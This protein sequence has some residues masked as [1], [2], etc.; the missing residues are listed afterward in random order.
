MRIYKQACLLDNPYSKHGNDSLHQTFW[1]SNMRI[2]FFNLYIKAQVYQQGDHKTSNNRT[3]IYYPTHRENS[4]N[5]NVKLSTFVIWAISMDA[6]FHF[7][8]FTCERLLK[9]PICIEKWSNLNKKI[10]KLPKD[11]KII[12][13]KW[14]RTFVRPTY[15]STGKRRTL[16]YFSSL[17]NNMIKLLNN[18]WD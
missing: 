7:G 15:I 11:K 9:K 6:S 17:Q 18:R 14:I 3:H 2:Y 8:S 12:F 16:Y 5:D 10:K 1:I 4:S 13:H